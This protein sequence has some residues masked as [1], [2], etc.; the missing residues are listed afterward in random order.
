MICKP[1]FFG[2]NFGHLFY[3][4]IVTRNTQFIESLN[5]DAAQ[6]KGLESGM[7][8]VA[9]IHQGPRIIMKYLL[10][11]VQKVANEAGRER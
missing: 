10:S 9:E 2:L 8:V 1:L 3:T 5:G 4:A 6:R 7:Q 11:P